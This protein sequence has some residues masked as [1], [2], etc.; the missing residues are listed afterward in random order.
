MAKELAVEMSSWNPGLGTKKCS[1]QEKLYFRGRFVS[2]NSPPSFEEIPGSRPTKY[3]DMDRERFR[4]DINLGSIIYT[5]IASDP[6]DDCITFGVQDGSEYFDVSN[7]NC[8]HAET[9]TSVSATWTLD[10]GHNEPPMVNM[11]VKKETDI[12][13]YIV[14]VNDNSPIFVGA[15]YLADVFEDTSEGTVI[16][17]VIVFDNDV[18]SSGGCTITITNLD[19]YGDMFYIDSSVVE[20]KTSL[21]EIY[22]TETL[23]FESLRVYTLNLFAVDFGTDPGP[24]N[25]SATLYVNVK[26]VQD[27]P[28]KF[29]GL[30]YYADVPENQPVNTSVMEVFAVDG[31]EGVPQHI[32]YG[33]VYGQNEADLFWVETIDNSGKG[34]IYTSVP[35][36]REAVEIGGIVTFNLTA[37]EVDHY[38]QPLSDITTFTG[39]NILVLDENDRSP[40]FD[41]SYYNGSIQENSQIDRIIHNIVLIVKDTDSTRQMASFKLEI[42]NNHMASEAFYVRP[43]RALFSTHAVIEVRNPDYLDFESVQQFNFQVLAYDLSVENLSSTVDVTIHVMD[44]N[45]NPP[46]FTQ[47]EYR[48]AVYE[49]SP[50]GTSILQ[51]S[52]T[53]MDSGVNAEIVY[54]ITDVVPL[55]GSFMVN[56]STGVIGLKDTLD[57]ETSTDEFTLTVMAKDKGYPPLAT[58]TLCII[59]VLDIDAAT[60]SETI[61]PNDA[62]TV[63]ESTEHTVFIIV[64]VI[65][66]SVLVLAVVVIA[67]LLIYIRRQLYLNKNLS[68][69]SQ[70]ISATVT[71]NDEVTLQETQ[72]KV[73]NDNYAMICVTDEESTYQGL[74]ANIY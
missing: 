37:T 13:V 24:L 4:E 47:D 23:D 36:D 57:S 30:P 58:T 70:Q 9:S 65:V 49:N 63:D 61:M 45:D 42:I 46:N 67:V 22:L 48:G 60:E 17:S 43:D 28:P 55:T 53:D 1:V 16:Y 11:F 35:L 66:C 74:Y 41:Q 39:V 72:P 19:D 64:I 54:S 59:Y 33:I 5:L 10:D 51:I 52:A 3:Y 8:T 68:Q 26:D 40:Y 38:N 14:N 56:R 71:H 25:S 69:L 44:M 50:A 32:R 31:D 27:M 21:A 34:I 62:R 2:A 7:H 12:T 15:P 20:D 18:G 73:D 29:I 6:E